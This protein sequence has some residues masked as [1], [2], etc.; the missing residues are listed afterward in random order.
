MMRRSLAALLLVLM[1]SSALAQQQPQRNRGPGPCFTPKEAEAEAEVRTGVQLREIL[2]R[3]VQIDPGGQVY[4]DDWYAFD[5]ENAERLRA[6]VDL[7]RQA[8]ARIYP[9]R[10]QAA[11]W[12]TDSIVATMKAVQ[13]NDAVC[14]ATYDVIERI[15]TEKLKGFQYYVKLQG[16]LLANEIPLCRR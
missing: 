6:A 14:K 12:E 3:C 2:R 1:T 11:Q 13:V 16:S 9:N 10:S 4:L 8:I 15:K 7:R 5:Q